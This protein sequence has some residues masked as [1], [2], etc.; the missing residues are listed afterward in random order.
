ML[1][2]LA[3][4]GACQSEAPQVE[5]THYPGITVKATLPGPSESRA[6]V[7]YGCQD[8]DREIFTW[9]DGNSY[10]GDN[11]TLFNITRFTDYH[12]QETAP[13]LWLDKVDG[14]KAQFVFDPETDAEQEAW[15]KFRAL[16]QP[17]DVILAVL[18]TAS[19]VN[20]SDA[21]GLPNLI[22]FS[23]QSSLYDQKIVKNPTTATALRHVHKMMRMYDIV[24]VD[25]DGE[26]PE[27]YFKHLSAMFRVSL[28]N[29]TGRPLFTGNTEFT[30]ILHPK[31]DGNAFIYGFNRL[32]VVGDD[33]QGYS[34]VQNFL[35]EEGFVTN[36][37]SHFVNSIGGE[38]L[39]D[40]E[41]YEFYAVVYPYLGH[42]PV[43][44]AFTIELYT[45]V[46]SG[47]GVYDN[48]KKYSI[49]LDHFDRPVEAGLRY[50]FNL[51]AM[52]DENGE[53]KL[54]LTRTLGNQD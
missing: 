26:L 34:L 24:K 21:Q 12:Q 43:G 27:L 29:R 15:D 42:E 18:G 14:L 33:T 13:M 31:T 6:V 51:T 37:V 54:V 48:V 8:D 36:E 10:D 5:K 39:E 7:E 40:G 46:K 9:L 47:Y 3:A 25:D 32:S 19:S 1:P 53:P 50:W 41:D 49:T 44:D 30:F 35:R 20:I 17:G 16:M 11:I 4:L 45:G 52:D 38:P 23:A 2:L 22:S 28:R